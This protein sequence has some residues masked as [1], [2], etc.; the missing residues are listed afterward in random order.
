MKASGQSDFLD[1]ELKTS[2][3]V[4]TFFPCGTDNATTPHLINPNEP[5]SMNI[6]V[7]NPHGG[8]SCQFALSYDNE[9]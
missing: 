1:L 2:R 7:A 9:T 8:G 6:S 4:R 3:S 5:F